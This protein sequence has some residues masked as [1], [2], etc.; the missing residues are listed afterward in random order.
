MKLILYPDPILRKVANPLKLIDSEVREKVREMFDIMYKE[1]GIG[2]AA[3]QVAWNTRLFVLNIAG[4]AD[5]GEERVYINPEITQSEGN[6]IEEEGC[7]SIPDIRARV[8]RPE[9]VT[10]QAQ[11]LTGQVF[12]EDINGMPART[13]QHELD[14]LDGIL[15]IQRVTEEDKIHIKSALKKLAREGAGRS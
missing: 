2:L 3:P 12:T 5:E 14:H 6:V 8:S 11:D 9:R 15:F 1:R 4:E 10:V 13:V 7:L